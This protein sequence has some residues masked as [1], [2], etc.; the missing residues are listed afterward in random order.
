MTGAAETVVKRC[1]RCDRRGGDGGCV[2]EMQVCGL[3]QQ[4]VQV[5][6]KMKRMGRNSSK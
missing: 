4:I 6:Q 3:W 2:R 1:G 5:R